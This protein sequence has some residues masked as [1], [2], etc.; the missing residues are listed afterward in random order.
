MLTDLAFLLM[1]FVLLAKG[2]DPF[3][4]D[5][6]GNTCAG[7]VEGF[8]IGSVQ[9]TMVYNRDTADADSNGP[10]STRGRTHCA[11]HASHAKAHFRGTTVVLGR[12]MHPTVRSGLP[13]G[14][15]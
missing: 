13:Y 9:T 15:G 1:G 3:V 8:G 14:T 7:L 12:A 5:A 11:A 10:G 2:A 6:R 4:P